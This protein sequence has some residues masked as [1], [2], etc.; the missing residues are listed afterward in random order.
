[1]KPI[2]ALLVCIPCV[3]VLQAEDTAWKA[4]GERV[5]LAAPASIRNGT[6]LD[7]A[8]FVSHMVANRLAA[9]GVRPNA[10]YTGRL[11]AAW[12]YGAQRADKG[13]CGDIATLLDEAF[14]GA[15]LKCDRRGIVGEVGG[16]GQYNVT[17]VNRDHGAL[18]L[19]SGGKVYLFDPWQYARSAG[20]YAGM[21]QGDRWNGMDLDTWSAEM[22]RQGYA[23][24][25]LTDGGKLEDWRQQE[26]KNADTRARIEANKGTQPK[27]TFTPGPDGARNLEERKLLACLKAW[28]DDDPVRRLK[29][30]PGCGAS[31][32]WLEGPRLEGD[33]VICAYHLWMNV[34]DA[35]GKYSGRRQIVFTRAAL[36]EDGSL[37]RGQSW[38]NLGEVRS[39][40]A[41]RK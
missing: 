32:E 29:D 10:S 2:A 3:F 41:N 13:S 20:T 4:F 31:I 12:V 27:E 19:V 26:I 35:E 8:R 7:K 18:A 39:I 17:N 15:G 25:S 23:R 38:F 6:D 40:C 1:M 21:G 36:N 16:A 30:D 22:K 14:K 11:Q 5:I 37:K 28:V 9:E 34:K 24:I 33:K